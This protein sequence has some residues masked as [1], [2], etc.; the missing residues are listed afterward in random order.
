MMMMMTEEV[1]DKK[2][3]FLMLASDRYSLLQKVAWY[4]LIKMNVIYR[5]KIQ[6]QVEKE[7]GVLSFQKG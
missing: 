7:R 1:V 5:G 2:R 4:N 6:M 3:T